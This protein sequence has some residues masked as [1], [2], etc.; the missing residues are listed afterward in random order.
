MVDGNL[1]RKV[2][3]FSLSNLFE[4]NHDLENITPKF[5]GT[6]IAESLNGLENNPYKKYSEFG[7]GIGYNV[8]THWDG[9]DIRIE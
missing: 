9:N 7:L 3:K 8:N 2:P 5:C 1:A 6:I 4:H